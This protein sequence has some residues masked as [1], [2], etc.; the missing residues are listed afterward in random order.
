[1]E[2]DTM[3]ILGESLI[4]QKAVRGAN[5]SIKDFDAE[6]GSPLEPAFGGATAADL[7]EACAL[8]WKAADIYRELPLETRATFLETIAQNILDIGD[9][10][11]ERC[12]KETG[13]PRGRIEGERG[14]TVG[15][16]RMFAGVVRQGDFLGVRIDPA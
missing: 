5:G 16:L 12:I 2:T 14:R 8:A 13:L 15:Q 1:M 11:I 3:Q 9:T 6:S 4:G 7:E 10:L